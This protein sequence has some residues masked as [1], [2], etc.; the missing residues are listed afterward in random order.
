M[1]VGL[2]RAT[3]FAIKEESTAGEYE[4]PDSG[5]QF[6]PLRP[7][8]TLNFTAEQL[9]SDELLNDIGAAKSFVGKEST[10]GSHSAYL[11]HSG[12]EG[13]PPQLGLM[14]ES[15]MGDVQIPGTEYSSQAGTTLKKVVAPVGHN[16]YAGQALLIKNGSGYEIR[17]VKEVGTNDLYL[18]FDAKNSIPNGTLLGNVITYLPAPQGHPTFSATKYLGNGHAIEATAGNTVTE[19]SLTADA[20]GFGEVEF[21][22]GGTK[23]FFNPVTVDGTNNY[24]DFVDDAGTHAALLAVKPYKTPLDFCDAL[25]AAMEAVSPTQAFNV[26]YS[27]ETGLYS[28]EAVSS[29]VFSILFGTGA[30]AANSVKDLMGYS[31]I[32]DITGSL[33]YESD[34]P[35]E[36]SSPIDPIYDAADAI[37]IKG[38]ELFIGNDVDNA[39]ICAQSVSLTISKEV[40]DVDCICEET[41]V[42]EK[43]AVSRS[44]EMSVTAVLNK[45]DATLLDALLKN[46]G[47]SA[48]LNAGP[49]AGGNWIPGKCF[50]V[51]IQNCTVSSYTT[52]GDSFI[53]AEITLKGFVTS[54]QK[55]V[56][57]NFV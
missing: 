34:V 43:I 12:V 5:N 24:L 2:Q 28:I 56:Y 37:I 47:V 48:M 46:S 29:A 54:T 4:K 8:N 17:N 20:N 50:N 13:Q 35:S 25:K 51:Y 39:C 40:E 55:D 30:N 23:Y 31:T 32:V 21:S 41:G 45:Y 49:K 15:V 16:F 42:K 10:E 11:R 26:T 36:F 38:A 44:V 52:T 27:K 1:S 22:Y 33:V 53:Q 6:I 9:D 7:G 57:L 19:L 3:I 18:N 14:Y